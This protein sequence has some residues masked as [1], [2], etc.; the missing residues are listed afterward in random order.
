MKQIRSML[1]T[2]LVP[3]TVTLEG[4]FEGPSIEIPMLSLHEIVVIEVGT[5]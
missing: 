1:L 3:P 2:T 5:R 4:P